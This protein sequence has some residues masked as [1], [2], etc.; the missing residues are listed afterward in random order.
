MDAPNAFK[1]CIIRRLHAERN[2]VKACPAQLLQSG[3]VLCAV[4]VGFQRDLRVRRNAVSLKNGVENAAQPVG[5]EIARCAAAEV[6]RVYAV[7]RST[8][9][10]RTELADKR[11]D[12]VLHTIL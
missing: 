3:G 1:L 11:G 12:I 2:A 4:G 10:P 7:L 6:D 9:A 5:A 8:G